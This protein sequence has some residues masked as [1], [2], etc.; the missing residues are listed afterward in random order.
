MPHCIAYRGDCRCTNS[1][2]NIW[3]AMLSDSDFDC[4]SSVKGINSML[5]KGEGR[6][7]QE[8]WE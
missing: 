1:G 8:S 4:I 3:L 7:D 2:D 6:Q 5:K